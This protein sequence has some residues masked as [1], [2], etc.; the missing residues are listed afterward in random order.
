MQ[1]VTKRSFL[2]NLLLAG[3]L[4]FGVL[5][6][7]FSLLNFITRHGEYVTVPEVK[8]KDI[9]EAR[10]LLEAQGFRVEV[11]DSVFI[12]SLPKLSVIKQSPLPAELVKV[13]R[14]I[15][16]T[17]N[18]MEPPLVELPGLVG[19]TFRSGE[20]LLR[21]LGL[22]LGDTTLKPDFAV[23]S[24]LEQAI[25]PGTRIPMGTRVDLVIGAGVQSSDMPVPALVGMTFAEAKVLLETSGVLLGAVV[26]DGVL[27]DSSAAFVY[28]QHP[29][30]RNEDGAPIRIRGGQLMDV[31]ISMD[32]S[33]I[34][35]LR[36]KRSEPQTIT[37]ENEY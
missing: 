9:A 21:A 32:R 13:N 16:L 6:L 30:Q 4:A 34:D 7:F 24:I 35:S 23:G 14:T 28:K 18:R 37:T 33:K 15:Y 10:R 27:T 25:A 12:D 36:T 5:F 22:K 26:A 2:F 1:S 8:G 29:P 17:V 20:M 3:S 31:W 19:Q 11:Q